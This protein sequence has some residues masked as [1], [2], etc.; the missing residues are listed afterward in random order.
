[1][2]NNADLFAALG[3]PIDV[4]CGS[5]GAT[6]SGMTASEQQIPMRRQCLIHDF[7][8]PSSFICQKC[9]LN[10]VTISAERVL[11][12]TGRGFR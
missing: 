5:E 12:R 11:N 9:G 10:A 1:M 6:Y 7:T 2:V 3:V 4:Y 8:G